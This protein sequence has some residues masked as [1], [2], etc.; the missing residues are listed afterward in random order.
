VEEGVEKVKGKKIGGG[1]GPGARKRAQGLEIPLN[2]FADPA[3]AEMAILAAAYSGDR[4]VKEAVDA[5]P[6]LTAYTGARL[7]YAARIQDPLDAKKVQSLFVQA[8]SVTKNPVSA[9][10]AVSPD[11]LSVPPAAAACEALGILKDPAY[12]TCLYLALASPDYRVQVEAARA[13]AKIESPEA[14]PD[15][16][17]VV[18]RCPW[19]VLIEVCRALGAMP[20]KRSIPVL[21][22]RLKLE[23]GRMRLDLMYALS[24]IAGNKEG[25]R[26]T[27]WDK[28][29][30]TH[31][32][33]FT[34]DP[35]RTKTFRASTRVQ[36]LSTEP[37]GVFYRLPINSDRVA[38]V[39]DTSKSMGGPRIANL[40]QS[41]ID[42]LNGLNPCVAF[43]IVN[44]GGEITALSSVALS[45]NKAAGLK[46]VADMD[47]SLGTRSFDAMERAERI[48]AV[49]SLYFLSDGVPT[50]GELVG[51]WADIKKTFSLLHRYRQIAIFCVD[52][53]PRSGSQRNMRELAAENDGLSESFEGG[54][55][56]VEE[57]ET[58]SSQ[59]ANRGKGRA[60]KIK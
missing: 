28:W 4:S 37:Y 20:D 26:F 15:L 2:L 40:K 42:V 34:V 10:A 58:P 56:A 24:S 32:D 33:S 49:D 16:L 38:F 11:Y 18:P 31:A 29:W 5:T 55:G 46:W 43:N 9:M 14:I 51:K 48:P 7:L 45:N 47:L 25:Y 21:L 60:K 12:L 54:E 19:P 52:F 22:N 30:K 17:A 3:S 13:I 39:L 27:D 36:D 57:A 8:M 59:K 1:K 23:K 6:D 50:D 44:F 35:E 53:D 41:M